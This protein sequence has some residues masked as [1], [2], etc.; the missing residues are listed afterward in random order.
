ME[1]TRM[2]KTQTQ[3]PQWQRIVAKYQGADYRQSITQIVTSFGP[4][5]GL[6]VLMY[7]SLAYSYWLTLGLSVLASGFLLRTFIIFH[8]CTHGSFFLSRRANDRLG[9]IAGLLSFTPYHE[10]RHRHNL[11][12]ATVGNL[13]KRGWWDIDVLT[14]REYM[15]LSKRQRLRYRLYRNPWLMFGLG[16]TLFFLVIQRLAR[17]GARKRERNSVY[18]TN[19][20]IAGIVAGMS[21][22]IGLKAYLMIQL[23]VV[24][25]SSTIGLWMF[26]V[27]HQFEAGYWEHNSEW[28]YVTASLKGSS[29]Y[30]L[31]RMLQW[32]TGN[33]GFHHIHHLSA[34]IPNYRL[35]ACYQENPVFQDVTVLTL[36]TSLKAVAAKLWDEEQKRM[37]DFKDLKGIVSELELERA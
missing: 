3:K 10:W 5:V 24:I 33:I 16:S 6:W 32:F 19:L 2:A 34:S 9:I 11:H 14:V 18:W 35:E 12:H 17:R 23:P 26:Y 27:Q 25:L 28:D 15:Q 4:Y 30:K 21:A 1:H 7:I 36:R 22:L 13:E 29:Y 20:A 31:P 8:D 37:I